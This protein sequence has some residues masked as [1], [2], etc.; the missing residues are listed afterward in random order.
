MTVDWKSI[1]LTVLPNFYFIE[2]VQYNDGKININS[3]RLT[4]FDGVENSSM[5][6]KQCEGLQ[7]Y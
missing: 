5:R 3:D 2:S 1:L 6:F 7:V 4:R